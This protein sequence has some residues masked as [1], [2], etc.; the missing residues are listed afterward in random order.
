MVEELSASVVAYVVGGNA[1]AGILFGFL[2]WRHGLE[3]AM[4]AHATAHV[5]AYVAGQL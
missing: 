1:A 4:I 5:L 2:F 3:S